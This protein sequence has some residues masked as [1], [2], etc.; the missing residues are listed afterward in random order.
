MKKFKNEN[1]SKEYNKTKNI[2]Y[3][4]LFIVVLAIIFIVY[5]ALKDE[6]KE[7]VSLLEM[8]IWRTQEKLHNH[9]LCL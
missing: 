7:A 8:N 4:G 1:V 3:I 2:L 5:V 6:E 9:I